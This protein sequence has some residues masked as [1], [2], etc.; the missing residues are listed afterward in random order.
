MGQRSAV[1][2]HADGHRIEDP[3]RA[4]VS[5][6]SHGLAGGV[7]LL[8]LR[9]A[10]VDEQRGGDAGK[11]ARLS[12]DVHHGRR[13]AQSQENVSRDVGDHRVGD[14]GDQR[15]VAAYRLKRRWGRHA[16][17]HVTSLRQY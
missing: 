11:R 12:R 6:R 17:V 2:Q 4:R 13:R 3:R 8:G 1:R 9:R 5:R 16:P 15:G 10:E 7:P 14:A